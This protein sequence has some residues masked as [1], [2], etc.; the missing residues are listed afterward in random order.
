MQV[1][2]IRAKTDLGEQVSLFNSLINC[3]DT[4]Y[5]RRI[6]KESGL[7]KKTVRSGTAKKPAPGCAST[8][9]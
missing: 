8:M 5:Q 4:V 1:V 7:L 3:R 9:F 2:S 6:R